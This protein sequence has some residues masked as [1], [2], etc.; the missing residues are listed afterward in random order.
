MLAATSARVRFMLLE[1]S[2]GTA[3][4]CQF[5]L[6]PIMPRSFSISVP[7]RSYTEVVDFHAFPVSSP[8]PW[9]GN[10]LPPSERTSLRYRFQGSGVRGQ[11]APPSHGGH[12]IAGGVP[13]AEERMAVPRWLD[14]PRRTRSQWRRCIQAASDFICMCPKV[15]LVLDSCQQR[16]AYTSRT[17]KR[18]GLKPLLRRESGLESRFLSQ[19]GEGKG[20]LPVTSDP[21]IRSCA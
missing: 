9:T 14:P 13:G 15:S 8:D 4:F 18:E 10:I 21:S 3:S 16:N 12:T 20:G 7:A 19:R 1:D 5:N 11:A 17:M 6:E 2:P